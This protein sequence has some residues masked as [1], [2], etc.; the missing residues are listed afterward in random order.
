MGPP[1]GS[2][3]TL[4]PNELFAGDKH[5][6]RF[7]VSL[8]GDTESCTSRWLTIK[9][10]TWKTGI[11]TTSTHISRCV[12]F[13]SDASFLC[14]VLHVVSFPASVRVSI[15]TAGGWSLT[16]VYAGTQPSKI[17][18][19]RITD[20]LHS[21]PVLRALFYSAFSVLGSRNVAMATNRCYSVYA[22]KGKF[23]TLPGL[24]CNVQKLT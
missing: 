19:K 20:A 9:V 23:F 2:W 17:H 1:L 24:C 10:P 21:C 3:E 7:Q 16:V 4:P 11:R 18:T 13:I 6:S 8:Y 14:S 5:T 15:A 22:R 12:H